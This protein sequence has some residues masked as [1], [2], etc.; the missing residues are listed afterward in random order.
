MLVLV[1]S[2]W[3][4]ATDVVGDVGGVC[5]AIGVDVGCAADGVAVVGVCADVGVAV[6][7]VSVRFVGVRGC[8][9]VV[10]RNIHGSVHVYCHM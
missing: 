10:V 5:Y 3:F 7:C 9:C 4:D 2:A 8:G 1:L 6:C